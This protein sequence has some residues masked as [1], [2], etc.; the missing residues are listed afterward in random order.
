[1]NNYIESNRDH[2]NEIAPINARSDFYNVEGFK[3]GKLSLL[4]I[5][6]EELGDVKG[7]SLLHLQCHFG[8]DTL[9]WAR[10]GAKVTGVDFSET[11]ID[12]AR[13]ISR[14]TGLDATFICSDIHDLPNRLDETFDIVF[15]SYGVLL[16]LPDLFKW[17]A[18]VSRFLKPGGTFYIVEL[19][20]FINVFDNE[21]GVTDFNV[22]YPYFHS[23]TP[24][25]WE[26]ESSYADKDAGLTLPSYEWVHGMGDIVNALISAGLKIEFLHEFPYCCY[27]RFPF[28]EKGSDGLYR[29]TGEKE[30]MIPLMFSIKAIK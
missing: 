29:M 10:L 7:L 8:L 3:K 18:L 25:K 30:K 4:P 2:W 11:S 15:T 26:S 21:K 14:E 13:S 6:R 1:M 5:E 27:E 12:L 28:M 19:H 22:R 16:W 9:S 17:A 24:Y 23:P 20:P